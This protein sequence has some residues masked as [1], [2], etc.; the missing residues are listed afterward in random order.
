MAEV[1]EDDPGHH[2]GRRGRLGRRGA[3]PGAGR[4]A[5]RRRRRH[6][7]ARRR[8]RRALPGAARA[9][10]GPALPGADQLLRAGGAARPPSG[11]GAS[12]FLLKQVRGPALVSAVHTVA[13]GGTM[14]EDVAPA[15]RP[16]A[17]A[18][19]RPA[20][21]RLGLLT[22]QE[23]TVLRLIGEGLTNRQIGDAHGPGGEDGEE[24]HQPPAGQARPRAAHAGGDPRHGAARTAPAAD[25]QARQRAP[26]SG[27]RCPSVPTGR[28][29]Q[30][31]AAS[32]GAVGEVGQPAAHGDRRQPAAVVGDDARGPSSATL[33]GHRHPAGPARAAP[34]WSTSSR[35]TATRS[36]TSSG[37]RSST[38]SRR[39]RS[40]RTSWP[41]VTERTTSAR[42]R[43]TAGRSRRPRPRCSSKIDVRIRAIVPSSSSTRSDRRARRR[44]GGSSSSGAAE[45]VQRQR[46][47]EDPLDDVVVQVAGDAVAVGLHLQPALALLGAGQLEDD[48]GLGGERRRAGPARRGRTPGARRRA[49]SREA[50]GRARC[51][52]GTTSAGPYPAVSSTTTAARVPHDRHACRCPRS[53]GTRPPAWLAPEAVPGQRHPDAL[54]VVGGVPHGRDDRRAPDAGQHPAGHVRPHLRGAQ[55][56]PCAGR[57]RRARPDRGRDRRARRPRQ[58]LPGSRGVPAGR[59]G[60]QRRGRPA[61]GAAGPDRGQL[62]SAL[63]NLA[64]LHFEAER[65]ELAERTYG[66]ALAAIGDQAGEVERP[67]LLHGRGS[68]AYH[69][70]RYEDARALL[71]EA[72]RLWTERSGPDDP[73]VATT[74]ANL[75]LLHWATATSTRRWRRSP[76]P[77]R[78]ATA[79]C[80]DPRRR[81]RAQAAGVRPGPAQRPAQ[82]ASKT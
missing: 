71:D 18:R 72:R 23:R 62:A 13:S 76:R 35:T 34:R 33:D 80:A 39:R 36:G 24:L 31:P 27:P 78:P 4:P 64:E 12:G 70:G 47:G 44:R 7:A 21:D 16:R 65:Y 82:G 6:A 48:R 59:G 42:R 60:A 1:L 56:P 11:A 53:A 15:G 74:L 17:R 46:G 55:P 45:P 22:D 77:P 26:S 51:R 28:T 5:R 58:D 30:P 43:R 67:F 10:P 9:G 57:I 81:Q 8:R 61:G 20:S 32:L 79:T 37:G 66:E 25:A 68:L 41:S 49:A 2:G 19:R 75:A 14:F 38:R 69:L 52:A 50:R 3:G 54:D 73:F 40:G 29:A 63:G